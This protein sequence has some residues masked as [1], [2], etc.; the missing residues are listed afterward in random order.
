[1]KFTI[2]N[3]STVFVIHRFS[4]GVTH[5]R[6]CLFTILIKG[7]PAIILVRRCYGGVAGVPTF[8]TILSGLAM[9]QDDS[10]QNVIKQ[11]LTPI[12]CTAVCT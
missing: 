3:L 4:D 7:L 5:L 9:M 6:R 8:F 10:I 12:R 2:E 11:D 1:M